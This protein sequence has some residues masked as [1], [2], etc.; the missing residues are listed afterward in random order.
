MGELEGVAF[1]DTLKEFWTN[2]QELAKE[3]DSLVK[4]ASLVETSVSFIERAENVY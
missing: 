4:R 1:Q 3:P 2:L